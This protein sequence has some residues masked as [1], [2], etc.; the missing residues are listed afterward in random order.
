MSSVF[1]IAEVGQ[2]HDGS[3]GFAHS[4]I[5]SISSTGADA[6][7]FQVHVAEAESSEFEPFRIN[8]SYEDKSRFDYWKRMEFSL[9]EW[10]GLKRHC[11]E[12]GLEFLAS[13]FSSTAVSLLEQLDV[14]RYKIGSGEITN[15]LLI[16]QIL[17]TKK[18]IIISSGLSTLEELDSAVHSIQE[19]S[20]CLS[21]LQCTSE[22]PTSP[23]TVG[24]N[25]LK[26]F[27]DRYDCDI[28]LSDHS[29]LIYPAI[30]ATAL[31]ANI[32]EAHIVYDKNCFGPDS[33]SSLTV[34]EFADMV[35][36]IRY[37]QCANNNPCTKVEC[38][39]LS[40]KTNFEKSLCVTMDLSESTI[41]LEKHLETKKP[42]NL[43]IPAACYKSVLGKKLNKPL[44]KWQFLNYIDLH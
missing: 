9:D 35:K 42:G 21:I 23:E 39:N 34:S 1:V 5:D 32:I 38:P 30:A 41:L 22:Y 4:Y 20:S 40:I 18:D 31:G 28:G 26:I 17:R 13:P 37:V 14:K 10:N 44:R 43:G 27:R 3:L 2:A 16:D 15:K 19:S 36:G 24:L 25:L 33:A 11:D 29:G 12:V 6:V 8:F 7:K